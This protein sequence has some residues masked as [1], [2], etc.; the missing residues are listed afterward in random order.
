[1]HAP[2]DVDAAAL[3]Y[4]FTHRFT[5]HAELCAAGHLSYVLSESAPMQM[6]AWAKQY[7]PIYKVR[8]LDRMMVMCTDPEAISW[9]NRLGPHTV[10]K[11]RETLKWFE[12]C[13]KPSCM[14]MFT[15]PGGAYW[16]AVR[17]GT[18]PAFSAASLKQVS[19]VQCAGYRVSYMLHG[20]HCF[21][22]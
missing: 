15:A 9:L 1:M 21:Q 5:E 3:G 18:A 10:D 20:R 7:G 11:P 17:L 8:A 16:K 19:N 6:A 22:R 14:N 4:M 12:T 2:H 13:T